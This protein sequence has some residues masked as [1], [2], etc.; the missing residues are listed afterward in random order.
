M[1]AF[2][3]G[4]TAASLVLVSSLGS[5]AATRP[6]AQMERL[7]KTFEGRWIV[8]ETHGPHCSRRMR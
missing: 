2:L 5:H 4:V 8:R 6:S 1:K 7:V 3:Y